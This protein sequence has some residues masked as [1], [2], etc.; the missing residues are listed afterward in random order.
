MSTIQ[1][2]MSIKKA[3]QDLSEDFSDRDLLSEFDIIR[4]VDFNTKMNAIIKE[5]QDKE[6]QD[7]EG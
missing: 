6:M 2:I 7:S 3:I 5:L 4:F 1:K